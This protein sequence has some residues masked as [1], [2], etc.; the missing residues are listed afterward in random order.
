[1]T[2]RLLLLL[3]LLLPLGAVAQAPQNLD[4]VPGNQ[5]NTLTWDAPTGL[6]DDETVVCY[7]LYRDTAE[8]P[9][10]DPE[11]QSEKRVEGVEATEG[12]PPTYTDTGLSEGQEYYY[13]VA[14]EVV[15]TE[16]RPVSCGDAATQVSSLSNQAS[17]TPLFLQLTE[18]SPPAS[19]D[20]VEAGTAVDVTADV[21]SLP[22][23]ADVL[24][25]SREGGEPTYVQKEMEGNEEL[26][27]T[28]PDSRVTLRGI[29]YVVEVR[30]ED[31]ILAQAPSDGPASI[32]V[33]GEVTPPQQP[34]GAYRIVS[35]PTELDEPEL[36]NI[37]EP[38]LPYDPSEWRL[39]SIGASGLTADGGY[40][41]QNELEGASL[42]AGRALWFI[43]RNGG[44]LASLDGTSVPINQPHEIS[45]DEG[46]NLIGNPFAFDVPL[47]QVR[48]ENTAGSL[49]D[50]LGYNG[51]NF[52]NQAGGALK[53]YR[54]YLVYL[55]GGQGGT[56]VVDPSPEDASASIASARGPDP[57]WAV[58][59]SARVGQARDPMNTFGTAPSATD[60]VEAAD[61]REPPPIGDYVSLRFRAPSQ[62]RGLWRDMRSTGGGL[63][64]WTAEVRTNVS[65]LV[66]IN[67]S[68]ISSVPD[69]Q[70][71]WLV[72]PVLDQSQNLRETPTYQ[73]PASEA[74]DARPLRILVGPAAAVQRRLGRDADRP[75]RV[76]L[77][78]SVP[79]PVRSHATF[80]Y[81]VP[82]RT[83]ATLEL[84]DL[85]GRRVA[86]LVDDESVGPG[87][88]T[89][90]WT[91]QDTGGTLSSG[92]YLLRLQ[93][94]DVTRT[95]RLVIMQ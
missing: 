17:A 32:R 54:G 66:T 85:L 12:T 61:G 23:G 3:G 68:G 10:P 57:R 82:E 25:R 63:R 34:S 6:D 26:T 81:R 4:A 38:L 60:G 71:V 83:R 1:M 56:L 93:A 64:T 47:S 59:L 15:E 19:P 30:D 75:E 22:S 5:E 24:L 88:H 13:R 33:E 58:D 40:V 87:T 62:N 70:S 48:V 52:V 86:T 35:F 77:L 7:G 92:A 28:I 18:P 43:R 45:L 36:S 20:P 9:S 79:H 90:A 27:R 2:S 84:Y 16:E 53:P 49:Q 41:E 29:E 8:I 31:E 42:S 14:A 44:A 67:A 39:F 73:F 89:Y 95:R 76:E 94:G 55:S 80:R 72:D 51:N 21:R 69:D 65:G 50:V 78:P 74:T 46:W 11:E 37:F 91:R